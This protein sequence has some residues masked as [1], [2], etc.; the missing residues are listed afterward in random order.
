MTYTDEL[1]TTNKTEIAYNGGAATTETVEILVAVEQLPRLEKDMKAFA[2]KAVKAG[3]AA[4]TFEVGELETV[5][6][7][8]QVN[9]DES[10]PTGLYIECANV[11]ITTPVF[12]LPGYQVAAVIDLADEANIISA[13]PSFRNESMPVEWATTGD[14]C[15]H[16]NTRR[17]RKT[18]V[19]VRSVETGEFSLVGK[20]CL[21]E[22][23]GFVDAWEISKLARQL[24]RIEIGLGPSG[25]G[26]VAY[27]LTVDF[28]ANAVAITRTL[29]F[30]AGGETRDLVLDSF[31]SG[32][33]RNSLIEMGVTFEESD[34]ADAKVMVEWAKDLDASNDYLLNLRSSAR[35]DVSGPKTFGLLA[36]LPK[37]YRR[38]VAKD[39]EDAVKAEAEA[40]E[41]AGR[42][43]S[44]WVGEVKKREVFSMTVETRI[45]M[46]GDYG[47]RVLLKGR[48]DDGNILA[49]WTGEDQTHVQIDDEWTDIVAG[50]KISG[51]ATVKAHDTYKGEK[52]T[53]VTRWKLDTIEQGTSTEESA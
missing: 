41:R 2:K 22:Y 30:V 27:A 23:V 25:G 15:D 44:C 16:C 33:G 40:A 28:V 14:V 3:L 4:P 53:T 37:A 9:H 50:F 46:D 19:A 39:A 51:K 6:Q 38:A 17:G 32:E 11:T 47:V 21:A 20:A 8:E 12:S 35:R 1:P 52:Q 49:W 13:T 36:S 43:E 10:F 31:Y 29:G 7:Y 45:E 18:L 34:L 5:A 24:S 26:G 42:P 48:D